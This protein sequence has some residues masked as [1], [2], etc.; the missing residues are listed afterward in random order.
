MTNVES[1]YYHC[2][3]MRYIFALSNS[4]NVNVDSIK[5][6]DLTTF[7]I[8]CQSFRQNWNTWSK[9]SSLQVSRW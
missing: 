7:K 4:T 1:V 5:F 2:I 6:F 9:S 3:S 8:F